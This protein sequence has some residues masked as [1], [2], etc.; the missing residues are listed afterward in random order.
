METVNRCC[1]HCGKNIAGRTDKKFCNDYCRNTHNN[2]LPGGHIQQT[3]PIVAILIKNRKILLNLLQK[4][5]GEVI[6]KK[7]LAVLGFDERYCT[8]HKQYNNEDYYFSFDIG[9]RKQ[10]DGQLAILHR[11]QF[12][13]LLKPLPDITSQLLNKERET[14]SKKQ[15]NRR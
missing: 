4:T 15:R 6:D 2:K 13:F 5:K 3:R 9:F 12:D 10:A 1:E 14:G 7:M 8:E 11:A